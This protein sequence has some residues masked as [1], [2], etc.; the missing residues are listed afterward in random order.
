VLTDTHRIEVPEF[1]ARYHVEPPAIQIGGNMYTLR[2]QHG[3]IAK[4]KDGE[5]FEYSTERLAKLGAKWLGR[6]RKLRYRTVPSN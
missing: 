3:K 6:K 5:P 2:D 4:M 1:M